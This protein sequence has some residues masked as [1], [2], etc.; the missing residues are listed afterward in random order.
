MPRTSTAAK[1]NFSPVIALISSECFSSACDKCGRWFDS[2]RH[3]TSQI[4]ETR[5]VLNLTSSSHVC[6][7]CSSRKKGVYIYEEKLITLNDK[8]YF[9][10][11]VFPVWFGKL[12]TPGLPEDYFRNP[13]NKHYSFL[14]YLQ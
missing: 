7:T 1:L 9:Q 11:K 8:Q 4:A 3:I 5:R 14:K 13:V 6:E 2:T 12:Q 10:V